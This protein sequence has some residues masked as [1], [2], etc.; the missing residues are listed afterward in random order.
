MSDHTDK[1]SE[2]QIYRY[3]AEYGADGN[4]V[5]PDNDEDEGEDF[6]P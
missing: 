6:E 4:R 2:E 5:F 1:L 3:E